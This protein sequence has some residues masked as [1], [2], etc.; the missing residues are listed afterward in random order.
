MQNKLPISVVI[1]AKNEEKNIP[2][3]IASVQFAQEIIVIDAHSTDQTVQLAQSLGAKVVSRIWD[4]YGSQKNFGAQQA[5]CNWVL[6]LDADERV[7]PTLAQALRDILETTCSVYWIT[8][9]DTFLGKRMIHLVGHNPRLIQKF[10]A[11]WSD[12]HVHEKMIYTDTNTAARYKDG[13]S[14]EIQSPIIHQSYT[15]IRAYITKMHRYTSLDANEMKKTNQHRSGMPVR[16]SM[17]LPYYL[18]CK[19]FVKLYFYRRGLLDG[20]QG[21]VW[22]ALSAYYEFEMGIKYSQL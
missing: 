16:Q 19:Q 11:H 22:C 20:W 1:I 12:A 18:A 5:S 8:I 2:D 10:Q 17:F 3:C 4:G 14:G 6:F 15:S 7:S 9:E 21:A 13:I